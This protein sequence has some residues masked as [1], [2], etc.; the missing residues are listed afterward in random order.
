MEALPVSVLFWWLGNYYFPWQAVQFILFRCTRSTATNP[1]RRRRRKKNYGITNRRVNF[2]FYYYV[3]TDRESWGLKLQGKIKELSG[4]MNVIIQNAPFVWMPGKLSVCL[5]L[6]LVH[7]FPLRSFERMAIRL[8]QK[9]N[10]FR[11]W[12]ANVAALIIIIIPELD[13][14]VSQSRTEGNAIRESNS[15]F[16]YFNFKDFK[17]GNQ[18]EVFIPLPFHIHHQEQDLYVLRIL[19]RSHIC[20]NLERIS[21]IL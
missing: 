2:W 17:I 6:A 19:I 10:P 21:G 16:W 7:S 18:S 9:M 5:S 8:I 20:S 14:S 4:D 11:R 12:S 15:L 1:I 3:A 13:Q